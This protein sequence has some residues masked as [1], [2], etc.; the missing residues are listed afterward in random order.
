MRWLEI[1]R[2]EV[3]AYFSSGTAVDDWNSLLAAPETSDFVLLRDYS[4]YGKRLN[5]Y[6][7]AVQ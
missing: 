7:D 3:L 4:P 6:R 5:R 2:P 1:N